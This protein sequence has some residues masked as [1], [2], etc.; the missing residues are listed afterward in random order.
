MKI[1]SKQYA[2]S[3]LE[4]TAEAPKGKAEQY[5]DSFLKI[6][7]D[8]GDFKNL[9]YIIEEIKAIGEEKSGFKRAKMIS[10][11]NL[12]DEVRKTIIEKLEKTFKTK[13]E[14]AEE[15]RPEI[16]GGLVIEVGNEILDSSTRTMIN[17]FKHNLS[18]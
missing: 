7:E 18:I 3:L 11:I 2:Q 8:N 1:T 14:L 4:A 6:V 16:L 12:S 15:V 17:K 5:L 9:P 13:I 10:A